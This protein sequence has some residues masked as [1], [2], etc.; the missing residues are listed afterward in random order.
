MWGA[1]ELSSVFSVSMTTGIVHDV[2]LIQKF[3][4]VFQGQWF[5][6]KRQGVGIVTIVGTDNTIYVEE[7]GTKTS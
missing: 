2:P 6:G 4:Y 3:K 5:N 1:G 7:N